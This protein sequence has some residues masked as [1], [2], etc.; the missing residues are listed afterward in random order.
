MVGCWLSKIYLNFPPPKNI[1]S[2]Q[3]KVSSKSLNLYSLL[4]GS[5]FLKSPGPKTK[6]I[7]NYGT[8]NI[9]LAWKSR[10]ESIFAFFLGSS[11]Y[12]QL[13]LLLGKEPQ[14]FLQRIWWWLQIQV[15]RMLHLG[16]WEFPHQG[17]SFDIQ[18]FYSLLC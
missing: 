12:K 15:S 17:W 3:I 4:A 7:A 5:G 10:Y 9:E 2:N 13:I 16:E 11:Y 18:E 6:S 1:S 14:S 8:I